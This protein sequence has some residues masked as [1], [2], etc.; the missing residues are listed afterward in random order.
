[1][2]MFPHTHT[3]CITHAT[4]YNSTLE[5]WEHN[6]TWLNYFGFSRCWL[7]AEIVRERT[8]ANKRL[9]GSVRYVCCRN[10]N[11]LLLLPTEILFA[12]NRKSRTIEHGALHR[13]CSGCNVRPA[14]TP[15]LD[16]RNIRGLD[17]FLRSSTTNHHTATLNRVAQI[18]QS[19]WYT[20]RYTKQTK[21][22]ESTV[23]LLLLLLLLE[24]KCG[25][26]WARK[27]FGGW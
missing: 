9:R 2:K 3:R 19:N 23:D 1:M 15:S 22:L 25:P 21:L 13:A 20:S 14:F 17:R 5:V 6:G 11:E 26:F 12:S 27:T 8:Y 24:M 7:A 16:S 4:L 10:N 18:Y